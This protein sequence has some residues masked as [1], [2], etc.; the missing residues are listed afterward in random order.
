[1]LSLISRGLSIPYYVAKNIARSFT[2]LKI[3]IQNLTQCSK[4]DEKVENYQ[5][6]PYYGARG[7][8]FLVTLERSYLPP[9]VLSI[10]HSKFFVS[11][12]I[13]SVVTQLDS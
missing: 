1:M 12:K 7:G 4:S 2:R 10:L 6:F 3:I 5:F 8:D 11:Q 13:S 9:Q